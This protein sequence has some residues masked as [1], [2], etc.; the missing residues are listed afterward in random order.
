M[1][2]DFE[3]ISSSLTLTY[4]NKNLAFYVVLDNLRRTFTINSASR[5]TNTS[6]TQEINFTSPYILKGDSLVLDTGF[7]GSVLSNNISIKGIKFTDFVEETLNICTEPSSVHIYEGVT[8]AN[9]K[10]TL[11]TGLLDISGKTFSTQ[12]DFYFSPL[13]YILD[14][15]NSADAEI[16]Q[17]IAGAVEMH[18]YYN[19][20]IGGNES[21]YG[22][23]FVIVNLD[24]STTFAL[25]QFSPVLA[26]NKI[27]FNFEPEIT[28]FGSQNT[29]ANV[30]NV[31]IYLEALT[32]GDNTFVF[33][34]SDNVYEFHNPCTGWTV[35]FI[36]ANQ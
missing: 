31:N 32:E 25:R 30:E 2:E 17:N 7:T 19:Y 14:N 33:K 6:I 8:S 1:A 28:L 18:L 11:E 21:L 23:G 29:D 22:I 4:E 12:S 9:D 36:N 16:S 34:L 3:K 24:G 27:T 10:V 20:D 13:Y 5:K 26:D 15:G 35:V